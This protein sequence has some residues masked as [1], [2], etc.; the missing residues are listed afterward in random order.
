MRSLILP[1]LLPA[2]ALAQELRPEHQ[3][4]ADA[5]TAFLA[6][7]GPVW[8]AEWNPATVTPKAIYGTGL[9]VQDA[10]IEDL[11]TA[12]R[13]AIDTLDR[14]AKLLGRGESTFVESIGVPTDNVFVLVYDQRFRGLRVTDARAD[15]RVHRS[16][17]VSMFGSQ[18]VHIPS[19]F[20][21]TP[22]VSTDLAWALAHQHLRVAP[23]A[24]A[25]AVTVEPSAE[26]V[27]HADIDAKAPAEP[28]L[29]WQ[30]QVDVRT[31]AE[32][33][34]GKV[35]VDARTGAVLRHIDEVYRCS[36]GHAHVRGESEPLANG[37][38]GRDLARGRRPA[39]PVAITGNVQ[40]FINLGKSPL[41][42]LTNTALQG[43]R[44]TAQGVGTA[45]TS[46]TIPTCG[47]SS[48]AAP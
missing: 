11:D 20:S 39:A 44:V 36:M 12:R 16:G 6:E 33:V 45:F 32:P 17:V 40:S 13:Y 29:A 38:I 47:H 43:L 46:P 26:L 30:V 23:E 48:V 35:F 22:T 1:L 24:P 14:Y 8:K 31:G 37:H 3:A 18:A 19:G 9:R 2:A 4:V 41:D 10:A 7:N 34:V 15:V 25:G 27:I 21:I 5:W 42:P 28:R